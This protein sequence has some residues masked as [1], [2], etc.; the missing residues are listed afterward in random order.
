LVEVAPRM[1]FGEI[2]TDQ[3]L[4]LLFRF[5]ANKYMFNLLRQIFTKG[6][7][8]RANKNAEKIVGNIVRKKWANT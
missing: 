8:T 1:C 3:F 6:K 7:V 4:G 5:S 2:E